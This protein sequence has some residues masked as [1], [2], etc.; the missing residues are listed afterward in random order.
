MGSGSFFDRIAVLERAVG[1]GHLVGR[2][3]VD[4]VYA[5]YQHE[6]AD[7][8]HPDGGQAFYLRAGM[9]GSIGSYLQRLAHSAITPEGSDLHRAMADNME[10]LSDKV[11]EL[12]PWEFGDLRESGHPTVIDQGRIVYDRPPHEHRL[13][14]ADLKLKNRLRGLG[15]GHARHNHRGRDW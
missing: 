1:T 4:Q 12:A 7:L 15:L 14:D 6:R 10:H 2:V 13:S 5:K 8:K 9:F 11:Y 3:E